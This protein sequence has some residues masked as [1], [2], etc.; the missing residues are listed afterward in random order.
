MTSLVDTWCEENIF[1]DETARPSEPFVGVWRSVGAE[2]HHPCATKSENRKFV[3]ISNRK[4]FVVLVTVSTP[5]RNSIL[6]YN[7]LPFSPDKI[8][9]WT[10]P[11]HR[12][13]K[14]NRKEWS[15]LLL[16]KVVNIY[17][18]LNPIE[19]S[20]PH[21]LA[22]NEKGAVK[23]ALCRLQLRCSVS[24]GVSHFGKKICVFSTLR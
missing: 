11:T 7:N 16:P 9:N 1:L 18:T 24:C 14:N 17:W 15:F 10:V 4:D 22:M 3:K 20:Q 23:L 12:K 5:Q 2:A 19:G 13:E 6:R 21:T 8:V